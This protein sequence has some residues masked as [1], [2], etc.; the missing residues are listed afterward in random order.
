MHERI[1]ECEIASAIIEDLALGKIPSKLL[2]WD[3]RNRY[4]AY[5]D[6][7]RGYG[8]APMAAAKTLVQSELAETDG[9]RVAVDIENAPFKK[10]V[11]LARSEPPANP[12]SAAIMVEPW[13]KAQADEDVRDVKGCRYVSVE[14][15]RRWASLFGTPETVIETLSATGLISLG[16]IG[17]TQYART[18]APKPAP[19]DAKAKP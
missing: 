14:N 10:G 13:F 18:G 11:C 6:A 15:L 7:F 2:F 5:P 1:S 19:T 12:E 16:T 17:D 3:G 8:M 9:N 4:L